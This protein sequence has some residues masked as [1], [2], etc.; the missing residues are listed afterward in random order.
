MG[1]LHTHLFLA[2]VVH[3]S[4]SLN[5]PRM[6]RKVVVVAKVHEFVLLKIYS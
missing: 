6:P 2:S 1:A 3:V 4:D 5:I